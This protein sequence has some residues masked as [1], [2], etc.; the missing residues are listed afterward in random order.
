MD[1]NQTGQYHIIPYGNMTGQR[2]GVREN[3]VI[4]D[5]TIVCNMTVSLNQTILS[6]DCFVAVLRP[7]IDGYTFSN[8]SV[9]PDFH[10]CHFTFKLKRSEERRVGKECRS[11]REP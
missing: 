8:S 7:P 11:L 1:G 9:I 5:N 6:D 4:T 2:T 10:R 3:T